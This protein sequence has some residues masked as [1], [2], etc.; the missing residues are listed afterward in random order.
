MS[1]HVKSS[2]RHR[3]VFSERVRQVHECHL[4]YDWLEPGEDFDEMYEDDFDE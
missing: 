1:K 4:V 3:R 2:D